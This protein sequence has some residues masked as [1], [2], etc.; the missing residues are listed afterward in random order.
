MNRNFIYVLRFILAC[1]AR[2]VKVRL[3]IHVHIRLD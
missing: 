3:T 2:I 1:V